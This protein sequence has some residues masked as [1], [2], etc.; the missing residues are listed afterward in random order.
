MEIYTIGVYGSTEESF[1]KKLTDNNIEV[2]CDIR[3][4]RGIRGGAYPYA[5]SNYLQA[6]LKELNIGY[7]H[8]VGLAPTKEIREKQWADDARN[9]EHKKNRE[10]LGR[11][12]TEEYKKQILASYDL[13]GLVRDLNSKGVNRIVLFCVEEKATA[14]HRSLVAIELGKRYNYKIKNL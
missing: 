7:M 6:K 13:D 10:F 9:G 4:R 3:Q 12:F 14:C 11:V 1:F 5:N 8:L 2:F